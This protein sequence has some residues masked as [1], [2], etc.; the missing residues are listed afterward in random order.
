M[1]TR[2]PTGG[3][4]GDAR[5]LR[6][7]NL[8]VFRFDSEAFVLLLQLNHCRGEGGKG[9]PKQLLRIPSLNIGKGWLT[10]LRVLLLSLTV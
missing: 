7:Q 5:L 9:S 3:E 1:D 6:H 4:A 8:W 2:T 10:L